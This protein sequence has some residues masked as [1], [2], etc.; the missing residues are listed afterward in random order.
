MLFSD[1]EDPKYGTVYQGVPNAKKGHCDQ[2][3]AIIKR[4]HTDEKLRKKDWI[5]IS[6]DDSFFRYR[7]C[8]CVHRA[9]GEICTYVCTHIY[10]VPC[11]HAHTYACTFTR[12]H[13]HTH[14]H[15][16]TQAFNGNKDLSSPGALVSHV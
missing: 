7:G 8:V 4:S 6:D 12:T 15:T 14:T 1:Q 9:S 5:V 16:H 11:V 3:L 13:T 2:T 10:S